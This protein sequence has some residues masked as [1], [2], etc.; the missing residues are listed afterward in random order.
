MPNI[1][2]IREEETKEITIDDSFWNVIMHND[3]IT[4]FDYVVLVLAQIFGYDLHQAIRVMYH[5]HENGQGIVATLSME[6]AYKK[7]E[8]VEAMNEQY[9][10]LLQTTVEEA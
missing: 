10:Q 3:D 6:A 5:I 1:G 9:N 2:M 7:M 8:E 4:P